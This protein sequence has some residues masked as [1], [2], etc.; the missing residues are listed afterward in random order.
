MICLVWQF[1]AHKAVCRDAVK[2][3]EA[4]FVFF[5]EVKGLEF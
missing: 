4:E 1:S 5:S 3:D 2:R